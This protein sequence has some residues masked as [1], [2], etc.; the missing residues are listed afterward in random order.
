MKSENIFC[1]KCGSKQQGNT[2]CSK[3]G[4]KLTGNELKKEPDNEIFDTRRPVKENKV[5][6]I[7]NKN[8]HNDLNKKPN[9]KFGFK[10]FLL[11]VIWII[12]MSV[13]WIKYV[14]KPNTTGATL[15]F[16]FWVLGALIGGSIIKNILNKNHLSWIIL[17]LFC[18]IFISLLTQK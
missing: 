7:D 2:F 11:L 10:G 17:T 18:I 15:T 14:L 13:V 4:N 9:T 8:Q 16:V 1:P 6:D 3:C 5:D 12:I